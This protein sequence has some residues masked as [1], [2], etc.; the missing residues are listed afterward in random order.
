[1]TTGRLKTKQVTRARDA[2]TYILAQLGFADSEIAPLVNRER[3]SIVSGRHRFL[4]QAGNDIERAR[5][6]RIVETVRR[7]QAPTTE[8]VEA[9]S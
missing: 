5:I 8:K 9:A 3:S 1:M 7:E 4:A 6:D 2:A